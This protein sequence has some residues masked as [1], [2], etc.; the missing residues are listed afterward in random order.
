MSFLALFHIETP[1]VCWSLR[2]RREWTHWGVTFR[3][4]AFHIFGGWAPHR[5]LWHSSDGEAMRSECRRA[6]HVFVC[7]FQVCVIVFCSF[8]LMCSMFQVFC[9]RLMTFRPCFSFFWFILASA[10]KQCYVMCTQCM[11]KHKCEG[12]ALCRDSA[13]SKIGEPMVRIRPESWIGEDVL[14]FTKRQT[15]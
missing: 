4:V 13:R 1:R 3:V 6:E 14:A 9:C 2:N 7:S 8:L 15:K 12:S 11:W 10:W 5:V